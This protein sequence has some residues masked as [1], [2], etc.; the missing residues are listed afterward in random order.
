[1]DDIRVE[2]VTTSQSEDERAAKRAGPF[3]QVSENFQRI[4][5]LVGL[6]AGPSS[7][8]EDP[9][10]KAAAARAVAASIYLK[11]NT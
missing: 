1:M 4:P 10:T 11:E 6:Y 7:A 5:S 3:R 2:A 8:R 9:E